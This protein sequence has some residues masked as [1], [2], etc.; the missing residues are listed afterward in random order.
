MMRPPGSRKPSIEDAKAQMR[1]YYEMPDDVLLTA[2]IMGDVDACAE[3]LVREIM[4]V[5]EVEWDEAKQKFEKLKADN[6]TGMSILTLPYYAGVGGGI[7]AAVVTVPM[8]FD[9]NTALWFNECYVTTDVPEG[10]DL[11][12][13]LEVSNQPLPCAVQ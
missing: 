4:S 5:D 2:S 8:C 1:E 12:T 7:L 13:W 9:L 11:E 10:K 3:R 6:M